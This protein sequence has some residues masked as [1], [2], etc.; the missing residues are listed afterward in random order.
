MSRLN[1]FVLCVFIGLS[2]TAFADDPAASPSITRATFAP[3]PLKVREPASRVP[4]QASSDAAAPSPMAPMI[5]VAS[6]LVIVLGLFAALVWVTRKTSK[7]MNGN[8]ELP[9]DVMRVLGKKSLG[10]SGSIAL[11][12]CGPSILV[13]GIHS[14]GMQRLGEITGPDEIRHLEALCGGESKTS[15][16]TTLAEMQREPIKRGFTGDDV[17]PSPSGAKHKLFA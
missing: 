1:L 16:N 9:N 7:G 5:T 4:S 11:V 10:A 8:R 3:V 17:T 13:V 12:R 15:F 2:T 14:S 6:S